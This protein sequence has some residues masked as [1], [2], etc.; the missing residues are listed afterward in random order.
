MRLWNDARAWGWPARA[1]HWAMAGVIVFMLG[2]GAFTAW[3]FAEDD[4]AKYAW[5]Q[6]HKSWGFVA[7]ALLAVR[8]AWR[9]A[10]REAPG[11]APGEGRLARAAAGAAHVAMY[12]LMAAVPLSGWLMASASEMQ[13][14]F[15]I[16]NEVF[17]L[18]ALPDPFAPGNAA[19]EGWFR[20]VHGWGAAAL[21]TL[22]LL[23]V[24]AALRHHLRRDGVLARM[25]F[26]G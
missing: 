2:L 8:A 22:V 14:L 21:A 1:L 4:F 19:L 10:N 3:G 16:R 7:F 5:V 11:A 13:D 26:G 6:L 17:G 9:W 15:G 23:H 25:T 18:F 12:G 20:T 24:A